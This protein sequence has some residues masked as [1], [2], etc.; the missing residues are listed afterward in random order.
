MDEKQGSLSDLKH[1]TLAK[2][3]TPQSIEWYSPGQ[4]REFEVDGN[5]ISVR[6]VERRGR[7]GRI[8]VVLP[9]MPTPDDGESGSGPLPSRG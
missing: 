6:F 9:L 5:R 4:T 8:A 7:R 1:H 2:S 3:G